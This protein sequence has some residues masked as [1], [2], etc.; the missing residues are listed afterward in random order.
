MSPKSKQQ[1]AI[2]R[3]RSIGA[4]KQAALQLFAR[5][6]YAYTS[7]S[8]IATEAG[9]SKGLM[10]NYFSSKEAL[11]E[12]IVSEA[13]DEGWKLMEATISDNSRDPV[14]QLRQLVEASVLMVKSNLNFWKFMTSLAFQIDVMERLEPLLK[15][16]REAATQLA[17]QMFER[18]GRSEPLKEAYLFGAALDGLFLYY[19]ILEPEF[20]LEEMSDF[21]IKKLIG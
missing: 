6:G 7:I 19:M 11:L 1:F 12:A 2:E 13:V 15:R 3:E 9:I 14:E 10:Y 21:L 17:V 16:Q 4:I 8:D 20:H 5:K 18:M